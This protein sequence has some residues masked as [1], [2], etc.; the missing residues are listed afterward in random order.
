MFNLRG[1]VSPV[2]FRRKVAAHETRLATPSSP[3]RETVQLLIQLVQRAQREHGG[4]VR[5][6]QALEVASLEERALLPLH[7]FGAKSFGHL[8]T[9][10]LGAAVGGLQLSSCGKPNGSGSYCVREASK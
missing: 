1:V 5:A 4:A 9:R 6:V 3:A 10:C 2:R 7:R 8:L